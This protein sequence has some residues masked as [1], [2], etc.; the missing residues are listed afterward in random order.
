[1]M[2]GRNQGWEN[3]RA[4]MADDDDAYAFPILSLGLTACG[5]LLLESAAPNEGASSVAQGVIFQP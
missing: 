5:H 3:K 1:M 2:E 4:E